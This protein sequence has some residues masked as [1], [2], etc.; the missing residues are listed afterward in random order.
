MFD[1][2]SVGLLAVCNTMTLHCNHVLEH[3]WNAWVSKQARDKIKRKCMWVYI[4][5]SFELVT[6]NQTLNVL[7]TFK[8]TPLSSSGESARGT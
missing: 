8:Y 5:F 3:N 6:I 7:S 1:S 4:K 2:S